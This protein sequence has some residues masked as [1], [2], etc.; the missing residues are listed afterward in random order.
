MTDPRLPST[1][2]RRAAL[3]A[4]ATLVLAACNRGTDQASVPAEPPVTIL[5]PES[6][7]VIDSVNLR[8]GP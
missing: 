2:R 1:R 4:A 5:G 7:V 8:T 6:V 3:L